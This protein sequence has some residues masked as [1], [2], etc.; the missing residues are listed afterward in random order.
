MSSEG[1]AGSGDGGGGG[2]QKKNDPS[3]ACQFF[4]ECRK[5]YRHQLDHK[6]TS[7]P[8]CECDD[9]IEAAKCAANPA[10]GC[11]TCNANRESA[12]HQFNYAIGL[13]KEAVREDCRNYAKDQY[14]LAIQ[15]LEKAQSD[16]IILTLNSDE[17]K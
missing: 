14:K 9:C 8:V 17:N 1:T 16:G 4:G 2:G 5:C 6:C 7:D 15:V 13:L 12:K 3:D 11:Q 10:C